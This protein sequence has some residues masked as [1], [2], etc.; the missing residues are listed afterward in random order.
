MKATGWFVS[1][2]VLFLTACS[3]GPTC[4]SEATRA[5]LTQELGRDFNFMMIG[6]GSGS[7]LFF[8]VKSIATVDEGAKQG[9]RH[10][11][12]EVE[13]KHEGK[14]QVKPITFSVQAGNTAEDLLVDVSGL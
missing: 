8:D 6:S 1:A 7:P 2:A 14:T 10:C 4:D 3:A 5:A 11:A 13:I 12:A 9:T